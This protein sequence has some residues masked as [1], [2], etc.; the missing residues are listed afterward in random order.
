MPL[1]EIKNLSF[2]YLSKDKTRDIEV[3]KDLNISFAPNKFNIL[4]GESGCGKTTL[5]NII[6]GIEMQ[7]DGQVLY[8][9]V[10]ACEIS[11]RRRN[12]SYM[13]QN[14][15]IYDKMSVF[16]N[17][18]FPLKMLSYEPEEILI[19]V[20]GIANR[21]GIAH[22]LSRKPKDLSIGQ[23]QRLMLA[24]TLVK[25][26]SLILLDES[27]TS[28]DPLLKEELYQFIKESKEELNAT[29]IYVTHDY[30]DAF[31]YG[32][33]IY[34]LEDSQVV[35]SGTPKELRDSK[36]PYLVALKKSSVIED[37]K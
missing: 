9:G 15:M 7:Y 16:E 28:L 17:I 1:I 20:R 4:L 31:R 34:V 10:D 26:P 32:E 27:L 8:D 11:I 22:C 21:L 24:K 5:L 6:S 3:F 12:M 37:L 18:A 33:M 14:Y 36:H 29:I 25:D 19:R 13:P 30:K 23:Q 35:V 2:N